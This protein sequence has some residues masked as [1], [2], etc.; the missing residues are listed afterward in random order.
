MI[1]EVAVPVEH[2]VTKEVSVPVEIGHRSETRI[3]ET[4][5]VIGEETRASAGLTADHMRST[6]PFTGPTSVGNVSG[7]AGN[8][9]S[10]SVLELDCCTVSE[11]YLLKLVRCCGG[12]KC[13]C[14]MIHVSHKQK[15][16][17]C[18]AIVC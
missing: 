15:S 5:M 7:V 1:R 9:T 10:W 4:R 17:F 14:P 12:F 6:V 3:G 16:A 2:V 8:N 13:V 18:C 11:I